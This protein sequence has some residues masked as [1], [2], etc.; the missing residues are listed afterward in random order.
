MSLGKEGSIESGIESGIEKFEKD[1]LEF[2][3]KKAF[4]YSSGSQKRDGYWSGI[5]GGIEGGIEKIS[6]DEI[7]R[8]V[9]SLAG[10]SCG[11]VSKDAQKKLFEKFN[12]E[13]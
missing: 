2:M 12:E 4:K 8:R 5:E 10:K 11:K 7:T 1:F 3:H 6:A 9:F 13:K